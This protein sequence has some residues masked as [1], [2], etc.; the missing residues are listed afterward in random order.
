MIIP[1]ETRDGWEPYR[2]RSDVKRL[3]VLTGLGRT[4]LYDVY[5]TG[6]CSI[7]VAAQFKKSI[8]QEAS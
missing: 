4:S 5:K 1:K 7:S 8:T 3:M 2:E 6:E